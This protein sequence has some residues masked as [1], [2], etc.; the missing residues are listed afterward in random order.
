MPHAI[1]AGLQ[2]A[3]VYSVFV[4]NHT[5]K[6]TFRAL[7]PD[8]P[9]IRALGADIVWLLPIHPIGEKARKGTL[10]SPYANRD[11]RAVNPEYG[12]L[13]DFE[14]LVDAIHEQG[15]KCMIDVVYNHTSPDSVLWET[16]P[17]WFYRKPDGN[18]GNHVGDWYD[19]IDLDYFA[20]P[21]LWDY[22]IESLCYWARYVDGFRCDVASFVPVEFWERAR[23]AVEQV[24]PGCIWLAETVH[25]EFA[26]EMRRR[27][28]YCATD[29]EAF[30]AFDMEY[31]YD[32]Q[33]VFDRW[34]RGEA[35]L[36]HYLDL[37]D[38]QE[39]AYPRG[40]N[41]MRYLENHDLPRIASR[42]DR[43]LSLENLTAFIFFLKGATLIYGGQEAG[44][45]HTVTLF[46]RDPVEWET[47]VDLSPLMTRLA[48]I[49]H[50]ALG[51]EDFF[52]WRA[53]DARDIAVLEREGEWGRAVGVFS[54]RGEA[55]E[56]SVEVPDGSY[57]N[58][59]DATPVEVRDGR[60]ETAGSPIIFLA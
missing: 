46:D 53:D 26:E 24:R 47:G 37:V 33:T 6:G 56:V 45:A 11:Y 59:I 23:A 9:R 10:G 49:K 12:T 30:A 29:A 32:I 19:I 54:L 44:S 50:E 21:A 58:L 2:Q 60:I 22:Q 1:N 40:F 43:G 3:V 5:Q 35:P 51:C 39:S 18:P 27:G 7:I 17:E 42:L 28:L 57:I 13:E 16:H 55:S 25:R 52:H 14:A 34:T 8:L 41:K 36:S 31:A 20:D 38:F 15:M 4:R 48:Q